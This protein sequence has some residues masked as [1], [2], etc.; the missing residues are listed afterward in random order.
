M[1]PNVKI[2][3]A[4]I[5][6]AIYYLK[7]VQNR[8]SDYA[9]ASGQTTPQPTYTININGGT[10]NG[11]VGM[12]LSNITSHITTVA[13]QGNDQLAAAL[14]AIQKAAA[15]DQHISEDDR[16]D[17]IDNVEYLSEAAGSPPEQ[18]NRG[19]L[20]SVLSSINSAA[21]AAPQVAQALESWGT[22]LNTLV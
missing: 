19:I 6:I 5:S 7:E 16:R 1:I 12:Q 21:T 10:I 2:T 17:L 8:M 18:R 3:Q 14:A 11:Q 20:R 13:E 4:Y 15:E 22:I 9:E